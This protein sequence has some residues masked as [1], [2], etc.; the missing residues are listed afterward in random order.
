[1]ENTSTLPGTSRI[2]VQTPYSTPR[3]KFCLEQSLTPEE[4]GD[5]KTLDEIISLTWNIYGVS[6]LFGFQYDDKTTLKLYGKRLRE[7][8]ATNLSQENVAYDAHLSFIENTLSDI[9]NLPLLKVEVYAKKLDQEKNIE[10]CI[11]RGFFLSLKTNN[12]LKASNSVK[13]P[14]LLCRGTRT[15]M[16]V[17]HSTFNR[18]FD[19]LIIALPIEQ[20]D[21]MWLLPII[22]LPTSEENY[23]NSTEEVRLEYIVPGL[24]STNTITAKFSTLDLINILKAIME[25]QNNETQ[26][27]INLT[28]EHIQ[29][30]RK[31]LQVQMKKIAGLELGLCTLHRIS[32]PRGT[33]MNNKMKIMH[34]EIMK[35]VLLYMTEKSVDM[36]HA[37]FL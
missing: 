27:V 13:L 10:K 23:P 5:I 35:R 26:I 36:L 30:F 12:D 14:L 4:E 31:C 6:A 24:S 2:T 18:M 34:P 37:L 20:D 21:L 17:V 28:I 8:I 22:I 7:E 29:R 25:N 19:C 33:L 9:M 16:N 15:C 1:M 3:L 32:L 11:Y